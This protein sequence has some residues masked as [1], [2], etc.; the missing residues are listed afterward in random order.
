[1]LFILDAYD[2]EDWML[3]VAGT[4]VDLHEDGF[5]VGKVG[6]NSGGQLLGLDLGDGESWSLEETGTKKDLLGK[7]DPRIVQISTKRSYAAVVAGR[8]I[9]PPISLE[10]IGCIENECIKSDDIKQLVHAKAVVQEEADTCAR[11]EGEEWKMVKPTKKRQQK[12]TKELLSLKKHKN[13]VLRKAKKEFVPNKAI[14]DEI[15][16]KP[17]TVTIT[18]TLMWG[19]SP[20]NAIHINDDV[21]GNV[22]KAAVSHSLEC[23]GLEIE[24][25]ASIESTL[26]NKVFI[27]N[28][29]SGGEDIHE[30]VTAIAMRQKVGKDVHVMN[31]PGSGLVKHQTSSH[32]TLG[33]EDGVNAAGRKKKSYQLLGLDSKDGKDWTLEVSWKKENLHDDGLYHIFQMV[34]RGGDH[35]DPKGVDW[36]IGTKEDL[37]G[38]CLMIEKSCDHP[39]CR[40]LCPDPKD[41]ENWTLV[42]VRMKGD[43]YED[44]FMAGAGKVAD[45]PCVRLLGDNPKDDKCLLLEADGMKEVFFEDDVAATADPHAEWP[46]LEG[47]TIPL[48]GVREKNCSDFMPTAEKHGDCTNRECMIRAMLV[49]DEGIKF[50]LKVDETND[51]SLAM[52]HVICNLNESGDLD[53]DAGKDQDCSTKVVAVDA[54][55]T[56][57]SKESMARISNGGKLVQNVVESMLLEKESNRGS[58]S[59]DYIQKE[60]RRKVN[61]ITRGIIKFAMAALGTCLLPRCVLAIPDH[62]EK[63]PVFPN[64]T[65]DINNSKGNS[66][67]FI[68]FAHDK[69]ESVAQALR[70]TGGAFHYGIDTLN[71]FVVSL[72]TKMLDS[73]TDIPGIDLIEEDPIRY[74]G[75]IVTATNDNELFHR[76]RATHGQTVPYGIDMVEARD[77]WDVNRDGVVDEGAP[78]G[79][80]K[81]ICIIDTGLK[82]SHED[83][84]GISVTGYN[85]D[86]ALPWNQ[87][88]NGHGTHVAGTIAAM[89]NHL[90]VV[91][92]TPGTVSLHI[93]RA[94]DDEG[95]CYSSDVVDAAT[96][97]ANAGANIISMSLGGGIPSQTESNFFD[98]L[99]AQGIL[100]I[101]A[102]GNTGDDQAE[103]PAAYPSVVSV[104]AIDSKKVVAYFSTRNSHVD[105]VAPGVD[106]LSTVYDSYYGSW[107]GTSMACPHVAAVAALVWSAKPSATNE[108]V[109]TAITTTAEDLGFPGRDD[110]YGHGLVRA[111][112]A[113]DYILSGT[114]TPTATATPAPTASAELYTGE[115]SFALSTGFV[116]Q[117]YMETNANEILTCLTRS[118]DGDA[119][120]YMKIGSM[121]DTTIAE[122]NDCIKVSIPSNE[123]YFN[124]FNDE[125]CS[126]FVMG[127]TR[128]YAAVKAFTSFTNATFKCS[129][130]TM[131]EASSPISGIS[132]SAGDSKY[133]YIDVDA[134]NRVVCSTSGNAIIFMKVGAPPEHYINYNYDC[135][136]IPNELCSVPVLGATTTRVIIELYAR[137]DFSDL[138]L[139]CS[140]KSPQ[141]YTNPITNMTLSK[142]DFVDYYMDI[143]AGMG[144]S[145][146]TTGQNGDAD[147]FMKVGSMA[148]PRSFDCASG[149]A[150][151]SEMC[152]LGPVLVL[153][154]VYVAVH[155]Y[156]AISGITLRCYGF[157]SNPTSKPTPSKPTWKPTRMPTSKPTRKPTSK[158]TSK[159][160]RKPTSKPTSKPTRK[161]TSKPTSKPTRKPTLKP[162]RRLN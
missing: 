111:K 69:R 47:V 97:C 17:S 31:V 12:S 21:H 42:A 6:A 59:K 22:R 145:C 106:I 156:S 94:C 54:H 48:E 99:T 89:N 61:G 40:L 132:S 86:V 57:V 32:K 71:T 133:Y 148:D 74:L 58:G 76:R 75:P 123:D 45:H 118:E 151:S 15:V 115:I 114:A 66:R 38:D 105:V 7:E 13:F 27:G 60:A 117:F 2:G 139:T 43:L 135:V 134:N 155:A 146:L 55:A 64:K 127:P 49:G 51:G 153:T 36:I 92:V 67:V 138:T 19:T 23:I 159:P 3:K 18:P 52:E 141:R 126:V 26:M 152:S 44:G 154:R 95:T 120:I 46:A 1:M 79:S 84:Q 160:T 50:P 142:N 4:K 93:S 11:Q 130:F 41:G 10:D 9:A 78:T 34:G 122:N 37:H 103:Y 157:T 121:A 102:A 107:S 162:T 137:F 81:K 150:T 136:S 33:E 62:K 143:T 109:L 28:C 16:D 113:I 98:N 72:P 149:D 29:T 116:R 158:P 91:G 56:S 112:K 144:M 104:G 83:L 87:D 53:G 63:Q 82:V 30:V 140:V 124:P 5:M 14:K 96:Q 85:V 77:V 90:G 108:E 161:P 73:L 110:F 68:K 125:V 20:H 88:S 24:S 128:V 131:Q 35:L 100:S 25:D 39:G 119:D 147:L 70:A 65:H 101:A 129:S 8:V 80:N